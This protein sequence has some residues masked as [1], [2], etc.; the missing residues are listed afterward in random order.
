[1]QRLHKHFS[2]T[3]TIQYYYFRLSSCDIY[4]LSKCSRLLT[5]THHIVISH[6]YIN[7]HCHFKQSRLLSLNND[8]IIKMVVYFLFSL[9]LMMPWR[10]SAVNSNRCAKEKSATTNACT[11][12]QTPR[13]S[14]TKHWTINERAKRPPNNSIAR[15][16]GIVDSSI[17]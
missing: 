2:L 11:H 13:Q 6:I 16:C 8:W 5:L 10:C 3:Q 4:I 14:H 12:S 17:K 1:M 7:I 9:I 15:G